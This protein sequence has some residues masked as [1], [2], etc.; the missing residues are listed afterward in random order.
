ML[1]PHLL[2]LISLSL[3]SSNSATRLCFVLTSS[4]SSLFL[5]FLRILRRGFASSS[6][7][8]SHLSFSPFFEFCDAALPPVL[9]KWMC[10]APC[11]ALQNVARQ[12]HPVCAAP[13]SSFLHT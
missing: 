8:P 7:P 1:R 12:T 2:L 13:P 9:E 6:P 5:S 11:F 3:L 4:F 10:Q